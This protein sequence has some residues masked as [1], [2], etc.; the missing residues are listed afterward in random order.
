ML[1]L[2]LT[3]VNPQLSLWG[4]NCDKNFWSRCL[5]KRGEGCHSGMN[6]LEEIEMV[7]TDRQLVVETVSPLKNM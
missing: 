2:N 7:V 3:T 5:R 1:I 4:P 6:L